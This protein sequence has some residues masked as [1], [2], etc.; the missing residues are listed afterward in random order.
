LKIQLLKKREQFYEIFH[1][2]VSSFLKEAI[3]QV[4]KVK[5][6]YRVN[7]RLNIIY[8]CNIDRGQLKDLVSEFIYHKKFYRHILQALYVYLAVRAPF[9][10]FLSPEKIKVLVPI[11][12]SGNWIFIP[13]NHSIRIIDIGTNSSRVFLK[14]GFNPKFIHS[15]AKTRMSYPWLLS[16]EVIE[17][18]NGW[19]Q[20]KRV[21]GLPLDRLPN[22]RIRKKNFMEATQQL[23][24]LYDESS[25]NLS[26]VSYTNH[27]C[28]EILSSLEIE[29]SPLTQSKKSMINT[30]VINL[31]AVLIENLGSRY[32]T[33]VRTHGDFQPGNILCS[34]EKIWII[35][36][37]YSC[38]RSIFYDALVFD[39]NCRAPLRL[40]ERLDSVL[41]T[42]ND[43]TRY[44]SWTG[45]ILDNKN[46]HYFLIFLIEDMLLKIKEVAAVPIYDKEAA[47][48]N[49][50]DEIIKIN[51]VI[52]RRR[53]L[54]FFS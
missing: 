26:A 19:F 47:L 9:E 3:P 54:G 32:V 14:T 41:E 53:L 43:K 2:S 50:L 42:L 34:E 16:P 12:D 35:D 37:E 15:D 8:P 10:K 24:K 1:N 45:E 20:E 27:L 48:K 21:I 30:Y 52:E 18:G 13:G 40:S 46:W 22:K 11:K 23:S 5:C 4:S 7:E 25:K 17:M 38:Y 29:L 28:D 36:W 6:S 51:T 31:R 49:Y 39:L 33:I 44:L